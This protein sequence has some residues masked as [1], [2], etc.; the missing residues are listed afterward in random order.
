MTGTEDT[1][2][3]V[4]PVPGAVG[5]DG[6]LF[7]GEGRVVVSAFWRKLYAGEGEKVGP[8]EINFGEIPGLEKFIFDWLRIVEW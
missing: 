1:G 2:A 3:A 5:D 4:R 7:F 8:W 6:S